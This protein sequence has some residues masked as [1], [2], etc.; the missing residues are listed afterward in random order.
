MR[1]FEILIYK[2]MPY[3]GLYKEEKKKRREKLGKS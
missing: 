2:Y 1:I 3:G